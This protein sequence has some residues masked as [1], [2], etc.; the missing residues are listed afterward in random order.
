MIVTDTFTGDGA[1]TGFTLDASATLTAGELYV[2]IDGVSQ[3]SD[4]YSVSNSVLTFTGTPADGAEIEARYGNDA[5]RNVSNFTGNGTTTAFQLSKTPASNAAALVVIDGVVQ[6]V[7]TY[8]LSGST[9]TFPTAPPSGAK[10]EVR[11]G[12]DAIDGDDTFA[13]NGTETAFTLSFSADSDDRIVAMLDGVFQHT[14][15]YSVSGDTLT[16]SA[17]PASGSTLEVRRLETREPPFRGA[18]V[19]TTVSIS[20]NGTVTWTTFGYDT[21]GFWSGGGG[22]RLTVPSGV[23]RARIYAQATH[24]GDGTGAGALSMAI[25]RNGSLSYDGVSRQAFDT[26][27]L[28]VVNALNGQTP[29]ISVSEGDYFELDLA[30]SDG[31]WDQNA[32]WFALDVIE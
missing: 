19:L 27:D 5:E 12:F 32:T 14:D 9:L 29:A 3:Q 17:A 2:T 6:G 8:T 1:T 10:I 24:A 30:A 31:T 21:D 25:K 15:A 23:R 20:P 16:M 26:A 7:M 28:S 22:T 11:F 4:A 18:C 13:G